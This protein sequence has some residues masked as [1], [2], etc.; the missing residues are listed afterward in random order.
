MGGAGGVWGGLL[1][2]HNLL[3][4]RAAHKRQ[5]AGARRAP[6]TCS[7]LRG[8]APGWRWRG[9]TGGASPLPCAPCTAGGWDTDPPCQGAGQ[10]PSKGLR[11]EPGRRRCPRNPQRGRGRRRGAEREV[12]PAPGF[13]KDRESARSAG[14]AHAASLARGSQ[15]GVPGAIP[16]RTGQRE[17]RAGPC[18]A[19]GQRGSAGGRRRRSECQS[20]RV[21]GVC[22]AEGPRRGNGRGSLGPRC[23]AVPK[24]AAGP[25][26]AGGGGGMLRGAMT[27]GLC[28]VL[29]ARLPLSSPSTPLLS[30]L[31]ATPRTGSA[32]TATAAATTATSPP[33]ARGAAACLLA[34][35]GLPAPTPHQHSQ[36]AAKPPGTAC[37]IPRACPRTPQS[38]LPPADPQQLTLLARQRL[39]LLF[40]GCFSFVGDLVGV[41]TGHVQFVYV[42]GGLAEGSHGGVHACI[43]VG[44]A[45]QSGQVQRLPSC[46]DGDVEGELPP[47]AGGRGLGDGEGGRRGELAVGS[48]GLGGLAV[49]QLVVLAVCKEELQGP[50]R[51]DRERR[52]SHLRCPR[53]GGDP[54]RQPQQRRVSGGIPL[55]AARAPATPLPPP[56]PPRSGGTHRARLHLLPDLRASPL[57]GTGRSSRGSG[58]PGGSGERL[59]G[60][61]G[62]EERCRG[63]PETLPL[64]QVAGTG[65]GAPPHAA[66]PCGDGADR[67]L[68]DRD[69]L[70][71]D[72]Q[73]GGE[74]A[75]R[76]QERVQKVNAQ[77]AQVRQPLQEPLHAC[78]ADLQD[79]AG[80]HRFTEP[81]VNII[82]IQAGI[83]PAE[84]QDICG[85]SLERNQ[86]LL[87]ASS[88]PPRRAGTTESGTGPQQP[89][90]LGR[91]G[92][93]QQAGGNSPRESEGIRAPERVGTP[94]SAQQAKTGERPR[95]TPR[96]PD[97]PARGSGPAAVRAADVGG[98]PPALPRPTAVPSPP[99]VSLLGPGQPLHPSTQQAQSLRLSAPL[100]S[101][102]F[103]PPRH[104]AIIVFPL[105]S[106]L[107]LPPL[108]SQLLRVPDPHAGNSA[109]GA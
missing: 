55:G 84:K 99:P 13:V 48:G 26:G 28:R 20:Q 105:S 10:S 43:A 38:P 106:P 104:F 12:Q 69:E 22:A 87:R 63:P 17:L 73:G 67:L 82:T 3:S 4:S 91:T 49:Q 39:L 57:A 83:R 25:A 27:R 29:L 54:H 92:R 75:V 30:L 37:P 108:L 98:T 35:R 21:P 58:G 94:R 2:Y 85:S 66:S 1:R 68:V 24:A 89:R 46:D 62:P 79:L 14:A 52:D 23:C 36:A 34:G 76:M 33:S 80:I 77:E 78:I 45:A 11:G 59:G 71:E 74:D 51:R 15:L 90:S 56:S 47:P 102:G 44:G 103:T 7:R 107:R 42:Q 50:W 18:A 64:K 32:T 72:D 65:T 16:A 101:G 70:V 61:E 95:G 86:E 40:W 60:E 31:E 88:S 9:R 93:T 6:C 96:H 8:S 100:S 5:E 19:G 53:G 41:V 97:P 109:P 81:N